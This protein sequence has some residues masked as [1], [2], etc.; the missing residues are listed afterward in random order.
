MLDYIRK[1]LASQQPTMESASQNDDAE[2]EMIVEYAHVFQE[3]DD[4]SVEGADAHRTRSLELDIPL[5]N[6]IELDTIEMNIADGRVMDIPMDAVATTEA[7]AETMR[8]YADFYMEACQHVQ[9]FAREDEYN[10]EERRIAYAKKQYDAYHAKIVQ[11]GLF[12]FDKIKLNDSRVPATMLV[13]FGPLKGNEQKHYVVKLPVFFQVDKKSRIVQSQLDAINR[14]NE[15]DPFVHI[16]EP[17]VEQLTSMGVKATRENIWDIATPKKLM[18]PVPKDTYVVLVAF[19][20]EGYSRDVY[21]GWELPRTKSQRSSEAKGLKTYPHE[22]ATS[23]V[24]SNSF[25]DKKSFVNESYV[26]SHEPT[27]ELS[28]WNQ[29]DIYQESITSRRKHNNAGFAG[30]FVG[31]TAGTLIAGI[32]GSFIGSALGYILSKSINAIVVKHQY[33]K[34]ISKGFLDDVKAIAKFLKKH[35]D[36]INKKDYKKFETRIR[37]LAGDCMMLIDELT[38]DDT[39]KHKTVHLATND[40]NVL[41]NMRGACA[42]II[43]EMDQDTD[44]LS[45][46]CMKSFLKALNDICDAFFVDKSKSGLN[47]VNYSDDDDDDDVDVETVTQESVKSQ[48]ADDKH[49][50]DDA[51]TIGTIGGGAAGAGIGLAAG[52]TVLTT[53]IGGVTGAAIGLLIGAFAGSRVKKRF[54]KIVADGFK[55]DILA[56]DKFLKKHPDGINKKDYKKFKFILSDLRD[57]AIFMINSVDSRVN[58]SD[59]N[60]INLT[61]KDSELAEELRDKCGDIVAEINKK[62]E[63]LSIDAISDLNKTLTKICDYYFITGRTTDDGVKQESYMYQEAIDFGYPDETTE[64]A[65]KNQPATNGTNEPPVDDMAA[66]EPTVSVDDNNADGLTADVSTDGLTDTNTA[67]KNP[68]QTNDVSAQIAEKI[69]EKTSENKGLDNIDDINLDDVPTDDASLNADMGNTTDSLDNSIDDLD[70]SAGLDDTPMGDPTTLDLD[71]MSI[72]DIMTQAAEKLKSM[73]IEQV[74]QFLSDGMGGMDDTSGMDASM[75]TEAFQQEGAL[76]ITPKT[77]KNDLAEAIRGCLGAL[78]STGSLNDIIHGFKKHG[79]RL[80]RVLG[81]AIKFT[82]VFTEDQIQHMTKL[83]SALVKL[84]TGLRPTNSTEETEAVKTLIHDFTSEAV[85]VGKFVEDSDTTTSES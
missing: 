47:D 56:Y 23:I 38:T 66:K 8:T 64:A 84:Q 17:L 13:D 55:D 4:L 40:I 1:Q 54:T 22:K 32:P 52:H 26:V 82:K 57:D 49:T 75:Q 46:E 6:D 29:D 81:K 35:P 73:P 12:G 62:Q 14:F 16:A 83:M 15:R 43:R 44:Q 51:L 79:K 45:N 33:D 24:K 10:L 59:V 58:G 11:E 72:D 63:Q 53:G 7:F 30:A 67:S 5:E 60:S 61:K 34:I 18:I 71:S 19:E 78:N 21:M 68:E 3:L 37:E 76:F 80:N 36:G 39:K 77:V 50:M 65:N 74:K 85:I 31:S 70:T 20:V 27:R 28:R 9:P 42:A 25:I 69:D 2:N 48:Y 41:K